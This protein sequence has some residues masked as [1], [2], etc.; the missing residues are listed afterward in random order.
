M[1]LLYMISAG[2]DLFQDGLVR[3]VPAVEFV[4]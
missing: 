1:I 4:K 3:F 2:T